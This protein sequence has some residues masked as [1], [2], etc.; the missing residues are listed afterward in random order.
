MPA[1]MADP[2]YLDWHHGP[3]PGSRTLVYGED[4]TGEAEGSRR[5]CPGA[6]NGAYLRIGRLQNPI[7]AMEP[8]GA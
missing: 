2:A 5:K 6:P 4:A 8:I 1:R 7:I 3:E